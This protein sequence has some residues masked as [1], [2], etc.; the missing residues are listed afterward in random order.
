MDKLALAHR[1]RLRLVSA[2]RQGDTY[3]MHQS[4]LSF[5]V[6]HTTAA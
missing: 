5:E 3:W 2:F 1:L 6:P 4:P